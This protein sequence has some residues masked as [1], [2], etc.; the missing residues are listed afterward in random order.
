MW[1]SCGIFIFD[2]LA[3]TEN[4]M[5][6]SLSPI[7]NI[8]AGPVPLEGYITAGVDNMEKD[9][10]AVYIA[11]RQAGAIGYGIIRTSI[12]CKSI[13]HMII[14][15]PKG[16]RTTVQWSK[17]LF[18]GSKIP[19]KECRKN[20]TVVIDMFEDELLNIDLNQPLSIPAAKAAVVSRH[21]RTVTEFCEKNRLIFPTNYKGPAADIIWKCSDGHEFKSSYKTLN[22]RMERGNQNVCT[23]CDVA[24]WASSNGFTVISRLPANMDRQKV[25]RWKCNRCER[26]RERCI[27]SPPFCHCR[28]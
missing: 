8:N 21:V 12:D 15:C 14:R 9:M 24:A 1:P 19:C 5:S 17:N 25:I 10:M 16:H 26:V 3:K 28:K 13:T 18:S 4:R 2:P 22:T 11:R 6:I 7:M 27:R 23:Y 20:E